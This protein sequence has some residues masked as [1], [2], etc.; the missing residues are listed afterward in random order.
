MHPRCGVMLL[1]MSTTADSQNCRVEC[2]AVSEKRRTKNLVQT[3][4]SMHRDGTKG[5]APN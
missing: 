4:L 2:S 5:F 3:K 1:Q